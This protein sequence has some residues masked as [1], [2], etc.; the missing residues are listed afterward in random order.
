M[1]DNQDRFLRDD[2]CLSKAEI[3]TIIGRQIEKIT[4]LTKAEAYRVIEATIDATV[5]KFHPGAT[6]MVNI[7]ITN[8]SEGLPARFHGQAVVQHYQMQMADGGMYLN[9]V[10]HIPSINKTITRGVGFLR[11]EARVEHGMEGGQEVAQHALDKFHHFQQ[12]HQVLLKN[13]KRIWWGLLHDA[14]LPSKAMKVQSLTPAIQKKFL[15]HMLGELEKKY[16]GQE[17]LTEEMMQEALL[18][19][20][21]YV[22]FD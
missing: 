4:D 1:T 15:T 17:E 16:T 3:G 5:L 21:G 8:S 13:I 12:W 22:L 11:C 14:K 9:A 20:V 2:L 6:I 10:I 7:K 19:V 18:A